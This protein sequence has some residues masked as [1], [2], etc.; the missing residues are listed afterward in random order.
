MQRINIY[1][2]DEQKSALESLAKVTDIKV[3]EHVRRAVDLYLEQME[4]KQ[5]LRQEGK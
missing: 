1:L 3:A 2:S 5:K 4:K